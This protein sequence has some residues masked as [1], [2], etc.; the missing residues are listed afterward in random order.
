MNSREQQLRE[1]DVRKTAPLL[2]PHSFLSLY[3]KSDFPQTAAIASAKQKQLGILP[4]GETEGVNYKYKPRSG[5][6]F[7]NP[8]G[9]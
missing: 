1:R 6:S 4:Q 9:N 3:I 7:D 8:A 5:T 2:D